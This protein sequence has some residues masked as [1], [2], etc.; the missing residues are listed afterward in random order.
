[1]IFEL[2]LRGGDK[3]CVEPHEGGWRVDG[4]ELTNNECVL[5]DG[6]SLLPCSQRDARV[7]VTAILDGRFNVEI[8]DDE[9][10][11][12]YLGVP[13]ADDPLDAMLIYCREWWEWTP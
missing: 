12:E 8:L 4:G 13:D 9:E 10:E 3:L 5:L 11:D 7:H 1:M 2:P 6:A